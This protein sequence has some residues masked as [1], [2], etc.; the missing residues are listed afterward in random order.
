M[1]IYIKKPSI[2]GAWIWIQNGYKN[3]WQDMGYDVVLF[4]SLEEIKKTEE[5]LLMLR[6]WDIKT[7]EDIEHIRN[8]KNTYIFAQPNVFPMPWGEHPNFICNVT[9][10]VIKKINNLD[11]A[12]LWTFCDVREEYFPK[13]KKV[14][15][16]PL[17]FDSV[18]YQQKINEKMKYDVCFVG[19][20]ANNGF[21]EKRKIMINIFSEFKSSGLKCGF[22]INKGLSHQAET[23]ILSSSKVCLNIHDAYQ[24]QLGLDTNERTFKSLGLNGLLVSDKINQLDNMFPNVYT[25]L[26]SKEIVSKV[27]EYIQTYD[28]MLEMKNNNR[29]NVLKNHSY[30]NRVEEMLKL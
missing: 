20:W 8:S 13:W 14:N 1:K 15:T 26:N 22:F 4:D 29:L 9:D 12:H 25:S 27:V 6:D 16:I 28:D 18:G 3:A 10:E 7:E 24:R 11:N 5:Y 21:D 17:A 30:T 23:E 19:G 2:N